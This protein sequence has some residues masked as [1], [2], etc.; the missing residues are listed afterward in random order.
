MQGSRACPRPPALA[1]TRFTGLPE[2]VSYLGNILDQP[3]AFKDLKRY[4]FPDI[5]SQS[6]RNFPRIPPSD[7]D[8]K[9]STNPHKCRSRDNQDPAVAKQAAHQ[10]KADDRESGFDR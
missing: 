4:D 1:S 5:S 3:E 7:Y 6:S 10:E 9:S 2:H 8:G